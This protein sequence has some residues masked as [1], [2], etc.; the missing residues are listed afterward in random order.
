MDGVAQGAL[1]PEARADTLLLRLAALINMGR[2]G[3]YPTTLDEATEAVRACPAPERYGQ[4]YTLAALIA[5][6]D[7]SLDRSVTYLVM[8]SRAL[9]AATRIDRVVACAW[10]DLA[11][12]YS[13]AGL[14]GYALSA[15]ERA[16]DVAISIGLPEADYVVPA[17]RVR[18]AIWHDH[19]G[20]TDA[21][22]RVLRD[23][24]SDLAWHE[25]AYPDGVAGI[26]PASVGAYGYAMARLA[27]LGETPGRTTGAVRGLLAHGGNGQRARDLQALGE[28]CLAIATGA[29]AEALALLDEAQ[30]VPM[31]LG[32][33]E[34]QRL[35]A[36]AYLAAGATGAAHTADR[37][38][39]R[40]ASAHVERLRELYVEA[41]A[42]RVDQQDAGPAP[43][44]PEPLTDPL[45]GLFT[46]RYLDQRLAALRAGGGPAVLAT[47]DLDG[48]CG[49]S[50]LVVQRVAT[51]L[52]RV[53]RRGDLVV[54]Y[55]AGRFAVLL[56]GAG[57]DEAGEVSARVRSAVSAQDWAALAPGVP[58]SVSMEWSE[59]N[60]G[61]LPSPA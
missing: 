16:R 57:P 17:I 38:A 7:G 4:L 43:D 8:S 48:A 49:E 31:T 59:V 14:H 52:S 35:R 46:R 26:R 27:A 10:H 36:L 39:F 11:M 41:G 29:P 50:E 5:N 19:H 21:C 44:G 60:A 18:L 23:V 47:C 30:F 54:R 1:S 45:T 12:A 15:V 33:A 28:V 53:V 3:E 25:R 13:Y 2:R 6:L 55:A 58:V 9:A 42:A 22:V 20:D 24:A 40:I 61:T 37:R 32:G 34:P 51:I 56:P